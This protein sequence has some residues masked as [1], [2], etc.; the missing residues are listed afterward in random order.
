MSSEPRSFT[1]PA[2]S[3]VEGSREG[4]LR[5]SYA[6][7][8]VLGPCS[9]RFPKRAPRSVNAVFFPVGATRRTPFARLSPMTASLPQQPRH[10]PTHGLEDEPAAVIDPALRYD[11]SIFSNVG[12]I[13]W[14]RGS[15]HHT[16]IFV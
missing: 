10:Q 9:A 15:T 4:P 2:L 11:I 13:S 12:C 8:F 14:K 3:G 6:L 7:V 16:V 5:Q 1:L